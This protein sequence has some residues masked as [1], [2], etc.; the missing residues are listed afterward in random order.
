[1]ICSFLNKIEVLEKDKIEQYLNFYSD[2]RA[3]FSNL[4]NVIGLLVHVSDSIASKNNFCLVLIWFWVEGKQSCY[5]NIESRARQPLTQD[6]C[7]R[8]RLH[9]FLVH[10]DTVAHE[11]NT[12][13]P[14]LSRVGTHGPPKSVSLSVRRAHKGG[15]QRC[16]RLAQTNAR[17]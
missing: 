10:L 8:A 9:R 17:R 11:P 14:T 6:S 5:G 2:A 4:D 13:A 15:P 1:M 3:S 7:V 16:R 12:Q